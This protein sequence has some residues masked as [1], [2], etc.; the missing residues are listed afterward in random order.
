MELC[1][2]AVSFCIPMGF[3]NDVNT[4]RQRFLSFII[5]SDF[6]ISVSTT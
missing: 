4:T 1:R 3:W 2:G 5:T 6:G